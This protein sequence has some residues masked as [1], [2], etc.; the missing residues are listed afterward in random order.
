LTLRAAVVFTKTAAA[1]MVTKTKLTTGKVQP[2][3][4]TIFPATTC[5]VVAPSTGVRDL[6]GIGQRSARCW[7][8][9]H[10][11]FE[12][13]CQMATNPKKPTGTAG[14][15]KAAAKPQAAGQ[16]QPATDTFKLERPTMSVQQVL[17]SK[18]FAKPEENSYRGH[19]DDPYSKDAL[20]GL[21]DSIK[22]QGGIHTPLLLQARPDETYEVGD[23]HRRF[24]SLMLLVADGVA[25][26]SADMEVPA[27]VLGIDTDVLAF[28]TA[29][30][31]ANVEREQ[32][33]AEGR[34]DA[35]LRLHKAGMPR[36]A[37]ADLLHASKSTIDRDISLAGDVEMMQHVRELRTI[38]MSNASL[39]L[40]TADKAKRRDEFK[41][42]LTEWGQQAQA[43]I[44]AEVAARASRDEPPLAE[45]Q[46]HPRS[47]MTA[48][49]VK[50]WRQALEKKLPLTMPG[51]KFM[52]SLSKENGLPRVEINAVSRPVADLSAADVA[53]IVRRCLDLAHEL[54]PVLA[55]KAAEENDAS[56]ADVAGEMASPGLD[57]L[58]ALG[59]SQFA[60]E[61]EDD[62]PEETSDDDDSDEESSD[63]DSE[64]EAAT[65][66]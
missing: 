18:I 39:L 47:R 59:F 19:E 22:M 17:L 3:S 37:I 45:A 6:M 58:R 43:A 35:T 60:G 20:K 13:I 9:K 50:H 56:E 26:F 23:G 21:M 48:E 65:Q 63:S 25:G 38:T 55:A 28:V 32:L 51:F 46:R 27:Q 11:F 24:Y 64:P 57:R 34:M 30:V 53:K 4:L 62:Q 16:Q 44:N 14:L 12:R 54:E 31:S 66:S 40:A 2:C 61:T 7:S 42:F 5:P 1:R 10:H 36:Q 15:P 49:M 52:A 29:S 41:M 8:R 33:P